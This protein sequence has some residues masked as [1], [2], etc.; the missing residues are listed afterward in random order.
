LLRVLF[1]EPKR[2]DQ[3][4]LL[5][6]FEALDA[7]RA[8]LD[9]LGPKGHPSKSQDAH[10]IPRLELWAQGFRSALDELEESKYCTEKFS[11]FVKSAYVEDMKEVERDHYRR[12]LYFYK[13]AI[14]RVFSVLDKLGYFLDDL[15]GLG[16]GRIKS[17][18]SYFTVLRQMHEKKIEVDLEQRLFDLKNEYKE[19]LRRLRSQRNMEIHLHN[20]E[21]VDDML[22]AKNASRH[23]GRQK[24]ENIKENITDLARSFEMVCRT[25]EFV[26]TNAKRSART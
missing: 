3:G 19:P 17:R 2:V 26:F 11:R 13:N 23:D 4:D 7:Y 16:T 1:N 5:K 22:I 25:V 18:F 6:A 24:V 20:A 14:I 21:M 8:K 9:R 15:Y 10:A 12:Y